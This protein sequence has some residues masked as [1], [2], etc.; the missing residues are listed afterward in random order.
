MTEILNQF[1]FVRNNSK[2]VLNPLQLLSIHLSTP[3]YIIMEPRLTFKFVGPLQS[4]R[5]EYNWIRHLSKWISVNPGQSE[6]IRQEPETFLLNPM[7][8]PNESKTHRMQVLIFWMLLSPCAQFEGTRNQSE[9]NFKS[10]SICAST[11]TSIL[12]H[13]FIFFNLC[14]QFDE[15]GADPKSF[16]NTFRCT[17]EYQHESDWFRICP[18]SAFNNHYSSCS[19]H[20]SLNVF[21]K[22]QNVYKFFN[23]ITNS[24]FLLILW[25][26]VLTYLSP[27]SRWV[28]NFLSCC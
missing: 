16:F 17:Y 4:N 7:I 24:Y 6:W 2:Q 1:K 12:T 10:C 14:A 9:P 3:N 22:Y 25:F 21:R 15:S 11:Y 5:N 18:N 19:F 26:S 20:V 13:L 8:N 23:I 27:F 28:K